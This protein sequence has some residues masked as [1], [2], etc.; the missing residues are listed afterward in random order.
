[1]K[2][3]H[4]IY[5]LHELGELGVAVDT[6]LNNRAK[7]KSFPSFEVL[8]FCVYVVV[9]QK[10]AVQFAFSLKENEDMELK[11]KRGWTLCLQFKTQW[12]SPT[13]SMRSLHEIS[14]S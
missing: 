6:F 12:P 10:K 14:F 3:F 2:M 1:M 7:R 13:T 9:W 5:S 11:I 8:F 4:A